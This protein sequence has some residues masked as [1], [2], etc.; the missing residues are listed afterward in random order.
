M[1]RPHGKGC[2]P[3]PATTTAP[4]HEQTDPPP[5]ESQQ[6]SG[7]AFPPAKNCV[8][9]GRVEEI[10]VVGAYQCW[11]RQSHIEIPDVAVLILRP[12]FLSR[13]HLTR[14]VRGTHNLGMT[15]VSGWFTPCKHDIHHH[16]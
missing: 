5:S 13:G 2:G 4:P 3:A 16:F 9:R 14:S 15:Q 7:A 6:P 8:R 10:C 11:T 12:K 1:E